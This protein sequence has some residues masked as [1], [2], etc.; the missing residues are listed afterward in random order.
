MDDEQLVTMWLHGKS[1]NTR[2]AYLRDILAFSDFVDVPFPQVTLVD[3][4]AYDLSLEGYKSSTRARKLSAIKSLLSFGH[5]IGYLDSNAGAPV[6]TPRSKDTLSERILE[7]DVVQNMIASEPSLRNRLI[8]SVLYLTGMRVSEL[9]G[10]TWRDVRSQRAGLQ[11]TIF[12]KG[13]R[14][15]TVLLPR[16][17]A[18]EFA[19]LSMNPGGDDPVFMSK[20]SGGHL[21]RSQVYRIVRNAA[22][23]I[24]LSSKVS[25]HWLRHAHASHALD[26]GA[27]THLVQATLGHR[28]LATTGRYAH[29]R[30]RDSSA[31][32]L[33]LES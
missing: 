22:R 11:V 2:D 3:L 16:R 6:K 4:Q 13:D 15:R 32:Y 9:C 31:R 10:I 23:R 5:R 29:A 1:P 14:T 8:L 17:L 25:P 19:Q 30:P 27:P 24:G 28:S 7:E 20:K 12:G 33:R 26:N 18:P 21:H